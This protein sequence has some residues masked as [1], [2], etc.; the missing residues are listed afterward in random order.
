MN[1]QQKHVRVDTLRREL[2]GIDSV[3]I[4]ENKGISVTEMQTL[5]GAVRA[6][7]GKV[8]V[9]KNTLARLSVK[10]TSLEVASDRL[11]GPVLIAFGPDIV[12]PAKAIL[13]VA[14]DM[15]KLVV[16]GGAISGKVIDADGIKMLSELPGKDELKAMF[17]GVLTAVAQKFVGTLAAAPRDFLSVLAQ[18][19][20]QLKEAA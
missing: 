12:G 10:G 16:K 15:P 1:K 19:E 9:V 5:R 13:K 20:E 3:I 4:A 6:A 7:G 17:L 14:K 2:D 8:R 11:V 18:R